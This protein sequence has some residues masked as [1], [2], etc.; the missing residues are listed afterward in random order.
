MSECC[1][2]K[3]MILYACSG[4]SDVGEITDKVARKL[5]EQGSGKMSCLSGIGANVSGYVETAKGADECIVIDG[6][7]VNCG[8]KMFETQ[9]LKGKFFTLTELGLE[10]GKTPVTEKVVEE[11]AGKIRKNI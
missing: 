1:K 8:K 11:M 7:P 10:K 5:R 2:G 4:A 6:C 3:N 9:K